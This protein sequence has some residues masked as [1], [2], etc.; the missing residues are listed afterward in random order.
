MRWGEEDFFCL[1]CLSLPELRAHVN[2][3]AQ[4]GA[5]I[6]ARASADIGP[7]NAD[8][9]RADLSLYR[10]EDPPSQE[11]RSEDQRPV[12]ERG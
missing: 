6:T 7:G 1:L 9:E 11:R 12:W 8:D 2:C 10:P 5:K 3:K 4:N